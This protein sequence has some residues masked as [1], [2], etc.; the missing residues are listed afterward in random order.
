M[1]SWTQ[2]LSCVRSVIRTSSIGL[3]VENTASTIPRIH[4]WGHLFTVNFFIVGASA[5][6]KEV[7]LACF[8]AGEGG[9][10]HLDRYQILSANGRQ[11]LPCLDALC[12]FFAVYTVNSNCRKYST[13]QILSAVSSKF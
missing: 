10:R 11:P 12:I 1:Q 6:C 8:E 9:G 13:A 2:K 4:Q 5:R 7:A 3:I